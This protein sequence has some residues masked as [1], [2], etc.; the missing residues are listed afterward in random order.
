MAWQRRDLLR[1][2]SAVGAAPAAW[3]LAACGASGSSPGAQTPDKLGPATLRLLYRGGQYEDEFHSVRNPDFEAKYPGVKVQMESTAGSDHY[4]KALAAAAGG[5]STDLIWSSTGSGGY[6]SFAVG[7]I[8]RTVDD[9]ATRDKFDFKQYYETSIKSL[10]RENK[11]Y[12]LPILCHPSISM[13][14][15]NQSALESVT[16][17]MPDKNW[18]LDQ[19]LEL[20]KRLTKPTG[21]PGS[22]TW[23]YT[24]YTAARG[25]K[26][27]ARAWGGETFSAD[28]KTVALHLG[29]GDELGHLALRDDAQAPR[30]PDPGRAERHPGRGGHPV[31]Q[32]PRADD[33]QQ[34]VLPAQRP[35]A[36][37]APGQVLGGAAPQ[38][39][40]TEHEQRLGLGIGRL[41]HVQHHQVPRAGLEADAAPDGQGERARPGQ[42]HRQPQRAPGRLARAGDPEREPHP[43]GDGGDDGG[44]AA[45]DDTYNTRFVEYEA[46]MNEL[47]APVWTGA[48]APTRPFMEDCNRQLQAV[49]DLPAPGAG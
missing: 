16:N 13:I 36:G 17:T 42:E 45:L 27:M 39:G 26:S 31:R 14:W 8:I 47:L 11:L 35:A 22:S 43:Q 29:A 32:R 12:G 2:L 18:T 46:K 6:F 9:I 7:K 3:A 20:C 40:R 24:V 4:T 1:A 15:F 5:T 25:I 37:Q 41:D 30:V 23:G 48:Q 34:H 49:L 38:A 33:A 19:L 28:G 21:D 10:R 44:G